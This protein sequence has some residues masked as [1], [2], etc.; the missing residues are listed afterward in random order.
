MKTWGKDSFR[1]SFRILAIV[2]IFGS[3]VPALMAQNDAPSARV[4]GFNNQLLTVYGRLFSSP[5]RDA[6]A[7]RSQFAGMIRQ[8]QALSQIPVFAISAYATGDVARDAIEAGCTEV[9]GK[10]LEAS[11]L[12]ERIHAHLRS[13]AMK[14]GKTAGA[15]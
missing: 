8:R 14:V 12:L 5:A 3:M 10:P 6:M 9:F 15:N 7:L 2:A 11:H 4:R 1:I 13:G